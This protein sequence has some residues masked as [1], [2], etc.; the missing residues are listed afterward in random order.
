MFYPFQCLFFSPGENL[1]RNDLLFAA[2]GSSIYSIDLSSEEVL[3]V[4]PPQQVPLDTPLKAAQHE[5]GQLLNDDINSQSAH[6]Q[7]KRQKLSFSGDNSEHIPFESELETAKAETLPLQHISI[8]KSPVIKLIG[9]NNGHYLIT[10]TEDK[11]IR[12]LNSKQNGPLAQ[13][14]ERQ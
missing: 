5:S 8:S 11:C 10:V 4:W 13:L 3:S 9:T 1:E 6:R 2:S 14:S 7:A 12:V